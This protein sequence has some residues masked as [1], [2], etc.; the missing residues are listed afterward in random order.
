MYEAWAR[1]QIE[2]DGG[3]EVKEKIKKKLSKEKIKRI[4]HLEQYC[5]KPE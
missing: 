3:M 5:A 1:R 4:D 2:G